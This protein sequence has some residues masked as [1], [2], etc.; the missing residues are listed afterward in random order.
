MEMHYYRDIV[1]P[2]VESGNIVEV[3]LQHEYLLQPEFKHDGKK[4]NKIEYVSDFVIK[5]KD[6]SE[7]VIDVK[8]NPDNI[9]KIKK[10][11]LLYKYPEIDFRW[12]TESKI[13]GGFV[14]YEDVKKAR[15]LRKKLKEQ[16]K[17]REEN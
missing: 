14:L 2:Q 17:K 7:V 12:L 1:K 9:S 4:V 5:Y 15:K 10:K 6:G 13:D 11:M 3:K 8:G 16:N